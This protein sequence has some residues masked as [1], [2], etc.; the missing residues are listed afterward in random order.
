[1]TTEQTSGNRDLLIEEEM[2]ESYLTYAMSVLVDRALPDVRDGLKPVHRRILQSMRDLNLTASAKYQKS[3]KIVGHALGNYHPHGDTSVYDAM[4]RM[5][6]DFSLRYL[7]VDGQGNF[8]SIDGDAAAAYRYTEARMDRLA[9]EMLEDIQY[10]TVDHRDNFDGQRQEPMVLPAKLPNLL[11][12]GS[13][14]IAVGMATNIPPHNLNEVCQAI[15]HVIDHPGCT[16]SDLMKFVRAPDFPTGGLICGTAGAR[17]AYET[18]RGRVIMRARV[19]REQ[20]DGREALVVTHIPYGIKLSTIKESI[21]VAHNEERVK[22][23]HSVYGGVVGD[24]IRLVIELKKGEDPEIVLNQLWE[25]TNLQYNFAINMIALD[26][27][28]PRTVSLKRMCQA[29][30]EHR[31]DVIVRRTRFWLA[32]DEARLHIIV[33]L[34]KAIDIIDEIIALIRAAESSEAAKRG[35]VE[36]FGFSELQAQAILDM[37][38]RRLTG[39]ERD[40]LQ[41]EHDELV[42]A[43][44]DYK[45]ILARDERQYA[46]IKA[47]LQHLIEKYGDSRRTEI[48][49]AA[50]DFNME[51]LI[52][53]D[54]CVVTIT[55]SGYIKRLSVDTFRIQRRGGKGVSGG[56]LKDDEDFV[57]QMFTATNHQYLLNFTNH[58]KVYWLKVYDIPEGARTSRGKHLANVL[59]LAKDEHITAVIPVREFREDQYLLMATSQGQVKKTA[60]SAYGNPRAGGIK[61]IKLGDGDQL[62]DVV[63]TGGNDEVLIASDDGQ[64]CRF[65]EG[66]C[67]PMGRDT[68]GVIGIELASG[69]KVVSLIRLEPGS[70]VLTICERGFGKRTP[71]DDYRLTRRGGKGVIN[72]ETSER[73]GSV[74]AS[75]AVKPG[76]ELMLMTRTG[77]TVR[78]RVDEIR[79]TGRAAQGVTII[80]I[81]AGDAVTGVARCPSVVDQGDGAGDVPPVG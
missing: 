54:P 64:A 48:V 7:L 69:A 36:N 38:L 51:D 16:V 10:D 24:G 29:Y 17:E 74:V 42:A 49:A 13:S 35:L 12:N 80:D 72:I 23:M 66:D 40:K 34:L 70:E 75:L 61:G 47:D 65:N 28:R 30:V 2:K 20:I 14:G 68:G 11:V 46:I 22:G 32:R 37:Q 53:D 45:D 31:K 59:S 25:H 55:K 1:M 8:G 73:N 62:V 33:G 39:L 4:V 6:Q 52:E 44:T 5:A 50:G 56:S 3:A 43:I 21:L 26:G 63:I 81:D 27:G 58:G 67:R 79:T 76:E 71:I 57:S 18:G 19:Q 9:G 60:L 41:A 15:I 78:T 77:T